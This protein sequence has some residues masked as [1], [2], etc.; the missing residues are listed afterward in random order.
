MIVA[1]AKEN[2]L[3]VVVGEPTAGRLLSANSTK[4]GHGY[5]LAL[6]TGAY[7]T[8]NGM[9]YEGTPIAPDCPVKFDWRAVRAGRDPL[10]EAA[11]RVVALKESSKVGDPT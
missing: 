9:V 4:V 7:Y 3:A 2:R 5:R 8:W 6:P 11:F 1:F 10:L